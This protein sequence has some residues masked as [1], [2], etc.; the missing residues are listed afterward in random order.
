M[1]RIHTTYVSN[2][3]LYVLNICN[4]ANKTIQYKIQCHLLQ[5]SYNQTIEIYLQ[6]MSWYVKQ[7]FEC[8]YPIIQLKKKKLPLQFVACAWVKL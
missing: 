7:N 8:V 6:L 1:I 4:E 3:A 2:F 5:V